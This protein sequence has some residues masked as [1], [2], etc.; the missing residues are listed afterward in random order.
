MPFDFP[1][2]AKMSVHKRIAYFSYRKFSL[3]GVAAQHF[4][5]HLQKVIILRSKR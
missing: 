4:L 5:T 3:I 2:Q 1:P